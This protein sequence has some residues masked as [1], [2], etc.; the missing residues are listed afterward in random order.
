MKAHHHEF[1]FHHDCSRIIIVVQTT[2][3][4]KKPVV[5]ASH[6]TRQL[7]PQSAK[8]G[9]LCEHKSKITLLI[10]KTQLKHTSK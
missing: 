3:E 10:E 6:I 8:K 9:P 5:K 7:I 2:K 1:E 4:L